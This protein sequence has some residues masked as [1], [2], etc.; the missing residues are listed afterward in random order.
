MSTIRDRLVKEYPDVVNKLA[1]FAFNT[2]K[3]VNNITDYRKHAIIIESELPEGIRRKITNPGV[4]DTACYFVKNPQGRNIARLLL[5][6]FVMDDEAKS[7]N[8]MSCDSEAGI[9][10]YAKN[11]MRKL[12]YAQLHFNDVN[13]S[14]THY[15]AASDLIEAS[16]TQMVSD[17]V[18]KVLKRQ[19]DSAY[20]NVLENEG[21]YD[22]Q[23]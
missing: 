13:T 9:V 2:Y 5:F 8:I 20:D 22:E 18:N 7:F 21:D 4:V 3:S 23:D 16:L 11:E 19:H 12:Y 10:F 14:L 1:T 17:E 6:T 15:L